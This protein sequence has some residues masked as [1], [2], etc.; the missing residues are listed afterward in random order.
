[1][2]YSKI[3]LLISLL[4]L[5][6]SAL[7]ISQLKV[8][9]NM[10]DMLP[11]DSSSLKASQDF[12]Q[13]FDGQDQV[14][15]IV[16][17]DENR[18]EDDPE[19]FQT[20]AKSY[21]EKLAISLEKEDYVDSVLYRVT[22]EDV[23]EFAWAYLP[24][25]VYDTIEV[26]MED[27]DMATIQ[28]TLLDIE[29]DNDNL[30][31]GMYLSS[32]TEYHYMMIL[33][34]VLNQ[35]D[36]VGSR[37]AFYNGVNEHINNLQRQ[38]QYNLLEVGLTGGGFIQ[39]LEAD[40]VAFGSLGST[41]LII[42]VLILV[43]VILFFG[44]LKLPALAMYPLILGA[45]MA[46]AMAYLI[47]GSL[48]MFSVSFALL[49][50]GLGIDFAV[51]LIARYQEER[52]T[53]ASLEMAIHVS[54]KSTGSSIMMGAATTAFAFGAFAFAKFKAFEQMGIIS[55]IG[56]ICLC[57]MMLV[58]MPVL[59]GLTDKN[60]KERK[61]S[62]IGFNWLKY[63]TD[64]QLKRPYI[65]IGVIIIAIGLL[66]TNVMHTT[67]ESDMNAIYPD[68]LPSLKWAEVVEEAYDINIDTLSVYVNDIDQLDSMIVQLT[69]REDVLKIESILDYMPENMDKKIEILT[70]LD[71]LLKS[72][73]L[74]LF[75][76]YDIR[77][78]TINDLPA[79]VKA[80]YLGKEGKIRAEIVPAFN[81]YDRERYDDLVMAIEDEIGRSPVGLATI[82]NEITLLVKEDMI[83]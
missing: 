81:I 72:T 9:S 39:D 13:Y 57:V 71:R 45:M 79:S 20:T 31:D 35:D 5:I 25:D 18:I 61:P 2:K 12:N 19:I 41:M 65:A 53:G 83:L 80:N 63:L 17:A 43:V 73:G 22:Y 29:A 76:E 38:N 28:K 74:D 51:H 27:N 82:M 47:Y 44:S 37:E 32:E 46:T 3:K 21:M 23:E 10:E 4:I 16:T 34:P 26:A 42:I 52:K 15:I 62:K 14:L 7:G 67:V 68:D 6:L 54:V 8:E 33:K 64:F 69:K 78:M 66:F 24:M 56:L 30:S 48:N 49:L 11:Q 60:Y 36:Y 40:R 75:T 55:A 58:L 50:L 70:K 59:I 77:T 1:M